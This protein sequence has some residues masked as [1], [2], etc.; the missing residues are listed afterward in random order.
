MIFLS[1]GECPMPE[2]GIRDVCRSA[3]R[4]GF[5]AFFLLNVIADFSPK[6]TTVFSFNLLWPG[7]FFHFPPQDG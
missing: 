5:V 4:L 3:V 7:R 6:K 2:T 1:D